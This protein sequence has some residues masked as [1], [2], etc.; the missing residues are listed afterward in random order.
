M[1]VFVNKNLKC[2]VEIQF[3]SDSHAITPEMA[4]K[5]ILELEMALEQVEEIHGHHPET[6]KWARERYELASSEEEKKHWVKC[7]PELVL[8]K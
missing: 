1:K 4:R 2:S 3:E 6:L 8:T 7:F 5:L